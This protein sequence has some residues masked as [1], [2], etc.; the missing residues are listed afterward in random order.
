MLTTLA[1]QPIYTKIGRVKVGPGGGSGLLQ[2]VGVLRR[3]C[4]FTWRDDL[5]LS[6]KGRVLQIVDVTHTEVAS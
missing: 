1:A 6:A 2:W 5:S 4:K 3:Q